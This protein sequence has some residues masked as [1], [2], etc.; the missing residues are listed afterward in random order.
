MKKLLTIFLFA[1]LFLSG[2]EKKTAE[3]APAE[4]FELTDDTTSQGIKPGDGSSVF[5]DA[6]KNY[7]IQVAYND[8]AS[9]YLVMSIDDIPY[10]D[11]ISTMIAN[12]FID[13]SP[14]SETALC[15][16]NNIEAD[17]LHS[18]L[19][20]PAYLRQHEV[21]YR[22]LRFVW[23][24]GTIARIESDTLDYNETFETPCLT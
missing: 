16:E 23:E 14:I 13:G 19:S 21:T 9:N 1:V 10:E 5:I 22:Y 4:V 2:C 18:L 17:A 11:N 3:V 12:F 6:Y 20:S 8:L 7:T 24:D 15:K